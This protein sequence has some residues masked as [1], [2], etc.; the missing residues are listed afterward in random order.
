MGDHHRTLKTA[1]MQRGHGHYNTFMTCASFVDLGTT[2][3]GRHPNTCFRVNC[4]NDEELIDDEYD[5]S[6]KQR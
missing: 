4:D 1:T 2:K 6:G 3:A 5:S